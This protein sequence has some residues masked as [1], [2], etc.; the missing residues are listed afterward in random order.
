MRRMP[1]AVMVVVLS[2]S[3]QCCN[4][5]DPSGHDY[6]DKSEWWRED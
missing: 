2:C 1:V 3:L 5:A 4:R 6:R